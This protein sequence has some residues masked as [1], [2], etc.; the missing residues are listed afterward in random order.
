M[1]KKDPRF[2]QPMF[3]KKKKP[4]EFDFDKIYPEAV[5]KHG[6]SDHVRMRLP[7]GMIAGIKA[8]IEGTQFVS[9]QVFMRTAIVQYSRAFA[10]KRKDEE[11][12]EN[13]MLFEAHLEADRQ[14]R[15]AEKEAEETAVAE[16]EEDVIK[17]KE[18]KDIPWARATLNDVQVRLEFGMDSPI[19]TAKTER[20]RDE[21]RTWLAEHD[22]YSD[23]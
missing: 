7:F 1:K 4:I 3:P 15:R 19:L 22:D 13:R 10:Q 16:I 20:A 21:L 8:E 6:H 18:L 11:G 9:P 5:D 14:A 2:E 12:F 23:I 17:I